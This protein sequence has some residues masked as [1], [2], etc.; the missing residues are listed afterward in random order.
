MRKSRNTRKAIALPRLTMNIK[1]N[2]L[3]DLY[4]SLPKYVVNLSS[5]YNNTTHFTVPNR[6]VNLDLRLND[7]HC[8]NN[9][10][11]R[12][13]NK[14][15]RVTIPRTTQIINVSWTNV[16][17][18]PCLF[19]ICVKMVIYE[20]T[21]QGRVR[22]SIL[23]I[24]HWKVPKVKLVYMPRSINKFTTNNFVIRRQLPTHMLLNEHE[25]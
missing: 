21:S 16:R 1:F 22:E 6:V 14:T 13:N 9:N 15:N 12:L 17:M 10:V 23:S 18:L 7:I 19:F 11:N 8:I 20:H 25:D 5:S 24:R 2:Y 4:S 3:F